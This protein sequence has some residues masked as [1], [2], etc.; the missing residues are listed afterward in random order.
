MENNRL[1]RVEW[2]D[3]KLPSVREFDRFVGWAIGRAA[4]SMWFFGLTA[5]RTACKI[6]LVVVDQT[7]K[8]THHILDVYTQMPHMGIVE[9]KY[10]D[11][12]STSVSDLEVVTDEE[13]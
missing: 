3:L 9:A 11:V 2:V 7:E 10:M 6:G 5:I 1:R 8:A 4:F 13:F 12:T